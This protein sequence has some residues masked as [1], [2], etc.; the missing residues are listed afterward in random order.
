M[1]E[2][3]LFV[4]STKTRGDNINIT[5][6]VQ[7]ILLRDG[8]FLLLKVIEDPQGRQHEIPL[9]F[10]DGIWSGK[11]FLQHKNKI[12]YQF[13]VLSEKQI[14][15][16]SPIYEGSVNY[17]IE[18]RWELE[19]PLKLLFDKIKTPEARQEKVYEQFQENKT[20]LGNLIKQWG[21]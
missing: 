8:E 9:R 4:D 3:P 16:A 7:D 2:N 5:F 20:L 1:K 18:A 19:R 21:L 14:L 17:L 12:R 11:T 6:E 15:F 13:V 10:K